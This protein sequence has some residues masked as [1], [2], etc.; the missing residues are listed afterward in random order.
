MSLKERIIQLRTRPAPPNEESAK[1]QVIQPILAHLGW[2]SDDPAHVFF[3]H[4]AGGGRIDIA[5]KTG[6]RFV[7][8]VE[9]KA[10]G[11][12]LGDHVSQMLQ[13]A[14]HEGVDICVLTNGL[15]WWL[16]LPREKGPPPARR[17]SVLDIRE[18]SA[19]ECTELLHRYLGRQ[20][21]ADRSAEESAREALIELRHYERLKE[22]VPRVW[23]EMQ[24]VLDPAL[25]ELVRKRVNEKEGLHATPSQV[26]SILG[27]PSPEAPTT[28]PVQ[29][30]PVEPP[31]KPEPGA[32]PRAAPAGIGSYRLWGKGTAV[33]TWKDML[34]GVFVALH[35]RHE[36]EF[37]TTARPLWGKHRPW[38]S[39]DPGEFRE[40]RVMAQTGLY[41]ETHMGAKA[42]KRRCRRLL[43]AFG[44]SSADLEIQAD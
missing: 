24:S 39:S 12:N 22:V 1:F 26:A 11:K 40:P 3:E 30:L 13:Y 33:K 31:A 17:F 9:A 5:L 23:D 27:W 37:L 8:F 32:K 43:E 7:A 25:V 19:D 6:G 35:A 36:V 28:L 44:H 14:F 10:P 4:P 2:P 42:I 41:A 16:Y 38:V 29:P 21:L 15:E 34:V 18:G 20:A